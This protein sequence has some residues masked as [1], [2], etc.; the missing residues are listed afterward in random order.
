MPSDM[1]TERLERHGIQKTV[2]R[3]HIKKS[4]LKHF[5]DLTEKKGT[6]DQ[7]FIFCSKT[8]RMIISVAS[9]TP[10]EEVHTLCLAA[11]TLRKD[12]LNHGTPLRFDG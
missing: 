11:P 4:V 1:M 12:V 10:K 7:V 9:Q 6:C 8:A 2:N 3:T 5:P